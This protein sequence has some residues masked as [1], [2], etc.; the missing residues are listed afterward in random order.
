MKLNHGIV[1]YIVFMIGLV[2]VADFCDSKM[3]KRMYSRT[4]ENFEPYVQEE[5]AILTLAEQELDNVGKFLSHTSN[6]YD[7]L[8]N[9]LLWDTAATTTS[10]PLYDSR[11]LFKKFEPIS[12]HVKAPVDFYTAGDQSYLRYLEQKYEKKYDVNAFD[13]SA[14]NFSNF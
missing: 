5:D 12:E 4:R 14:M 13:P 7:T 3:L 11:T 6:S 2:L 8:E 9:T 10:D 1:L